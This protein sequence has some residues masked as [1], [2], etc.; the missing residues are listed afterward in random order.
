MNILDIEVAYIKN[1]NLYMVQ[2]GKEISTFS[3]YLDAK[4]F[5]DNKVWHAGRKHEE[6]LKSRI[7]ANN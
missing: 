7:P 3:N 4:Y 1:E 6:F 5:I 2:I